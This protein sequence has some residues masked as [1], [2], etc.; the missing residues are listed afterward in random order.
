MLKLKVEPL[1]NFLNKIHP[2]Y[3]VIFYLIFHFFLIFL[4]I[5]Q[6]DGNINLLIHINQKYFE[7]NPKTKF[8]SMVILKESGYDGQFFYFIS[9]YLYDKNIENITIDS[10]SFRL[11]RIGSSILYGFFPSFFGWN[12]YAYF[13]IFLNLLIFIISYFLFYSLLSLDQ[14][15]I[16]FFYLFNPFSIISNMLLIGDN[17]FISF[18]MIF[19]YFLQKSNFSFFENTNINIFYYFLSFILAIFLVFLKEISLIFFIPLVVYSLIYK[20]KKGM[21][22]FFPPIFVFFLWLLFIPKFF[23]IFEISSISHIERIRTPFLDLF[24]FYFFLF[25]NFFNLKDF[26]KVI[27]Y[28]L[29]L[30]IFIV[31]M[32][33]LINFFRFYKNFRDLFSIKF[34]ELLFYFPIA[35]NLFSILIVDYEYWLAFD[36][37][38]RIFSI[39]FLW[40]LFLR[41]LKKHTDYRFFYLIFIITIL[42]IFRYSFKKVGEYFIL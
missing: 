34:W 17:F 4:Y 8:P 12:T 39:A 25:S 26:L 20:K 16:S 36:N 21:W 32:I 3:Y 22:L 23:Q 13:G 29:I 1:I 35:F 2:I 5:K 37:I 40:N 11:L 6:A 31:L 15:Y 10:S 42:L 33:Q 28:I 41:I 24:R 18:F 30:I 19:L 27:P 9:R 14:K 38:F 7:L